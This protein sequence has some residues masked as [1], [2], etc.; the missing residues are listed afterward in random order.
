MPGQS[1][2]NNLHIDRIL[3]N[4]MLKY[5]PE[6]MIWDMIAPEVTVTNKTGKYY[7]WNIA[8]QFRVIDDYRAPGDE[9]LTM[10]RSI[11]SDTYHVYP[12]ALQS[13]IL[14]EDEANAD[15]PELFTSRQAVAES[16]FDQLTLN[17]EYRVG[18]LVMNTS[19]VG[20]NSVVSSAWGTQSAPGSNPFGDID[21]GREWIRS[22]TG[23]IANSIVFG[24][25][26]WQSFIR[27]ANV[28]KLIFGDSAVG[29][30]RVPT[31]PNVKAA[32]PGIERVTIGGTMYNSGDE[33]QSASLSDIWGDHVLIYYAPMVPRR[34]KSSYI[35]TFNWPRVKGM[36]RTVQVFDEPK[37]GSTSIAVGYYTDTKICA[38]NLSFLLTNVSSSQ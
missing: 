29:S 31:F 15:A 23:V 11:S 20:S 13:P 24:W 36:N 19:N 38:Q 18:S 34:D 33:N 25:K 2:G 12:H 1:T 37:K 22:K 14:Y 28:A 3:T 27:D 21:T 16:I 7:V 32:L 30:A 17:Q 10:T 35:Y 6:N 9:P 4:I 5:R 26:A 8:D